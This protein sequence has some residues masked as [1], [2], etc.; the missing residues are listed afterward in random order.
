[1]DELTKW[2]DQ[3]VMVKNDK[4]HLKNPTPGGKVIK[5]NGEIYNRLLQQADTIRLI[6]VNLDFIY[7]Y[8]YISRESFE[9]LNM[10]RKEIDEDNWTVQ[11]MMDY[12]KIPDSENDYFIRILRIEKYKQYIINFNSRERKKNLTYDMVD[13]I[14]SVEKQSLSSK[15]IG[16][17]DEI[18]IFCIENFSD[19]NKQ[20]KRFRNKM[21]HYCDGYKK[22]SSQSY[23]QIQTLLNKFKPEN[24]QKLRIFHFPEVR[25]YE[26]APLSLLSL[27]SQF[28]VNI[29][30]K[31]YLIRSFED[32]E[33]VNYKFDE[34]GN[35]V[36]L[37]GQDM[38]GLT[39]QMMT[40]ISNELFNIKVFIKPANSTKYFLNPEF[41]FSEENKTLL[42][43]LCVLVGFEESRQEEII[44]NTE[45]DKI[46]KVFYKF[47]G[48]LLS[49]FLINSF[50]LP[51]HLSTYMLNTFKHKQNTIK[52]HEHVLYVLSDFPEISNT[53][54]NMMKSN[55]DD[56]ETYDIEYNDLYKIQYNK[57]SGDKVTSKNFEQ[58]FID[59]A[60]HLNMH[61]TIPVSE[62]RNLHIDFSTNYKHFANGFNNN[63][64][65]LFQHAEVSYI[66]IDK[67]LTK[68]ELTD[69]ILLQLSDNIYRNISFPQ[70]DT[71]S[72][73]RYYNTCLDYASKYQTYMNNILHN[74]DQRLSEEDHSKFVKQLLEFWTGI[75]FF[76]PEIRYRILILM[77][78]ADGYPV[79]HTCFNRID[80]PLYETEE[81]FFDSLK[82]AVDNSH[83]TFTIAGGKNKSKKRVIM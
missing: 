30:V 69:D 73:E 6:P 46:Y 32:I 27:F 62:D 65:K 18:S 50:K 68:E 83:S 33:I 41:Q 74:K 75:D 48:Q 47:L 11:T 14:K 23:E 26:E 80:F 43:L 29:R 39:R 60:K 71:T 24:N 59:Y 61:N 36:L 4:I 38:G 1:M 8:G 56:I 9:I 70:P 13:A 49:F 78:R 20:F 19:I 34:K 40:N 10:I 57:E 63:L 15:S 82:F 64:R 16:E 25:H 55:P 51:H 54:L 58:Y 66:D 79:S 28:I 37:D 35:I 45:T 5:E 76:K 3:G 67:M 31:N 2:W 72:L 17:N 81:K 7:D 52:E 42:Y 77:N 53:I 21:L 22:Q 12:F 44:D